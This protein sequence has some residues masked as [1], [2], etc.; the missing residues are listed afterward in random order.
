MD[1]GPEKHEETLSTVDKTSYQPAESERQVFLVEMAGNNVGQLQGLDRGTAIIGR[2]DDAD[3]QFMDAGIS[4]KHAEVSWNP[5]LKAY[6]LRDLHSR[7]GTMVN[8]TRITD[9]CELQ[10]GD[11]INLG[12]QT[13]LRVSY[14]DEVET[15][16]ASTMYRAVLRDALTGI[17][18]RRY[19]DERLESELSFATRH[20][21]SLVLLFLDIDHFK[22]INDNHEHRCGD[23]VLR[24]FAS[25]VGRLI[26]TEDIFAR[27]GGEEFAILCRDI[28]LW[29]GM[30]LA[31]RLR[32]A[33]ERHPFTFED[34]KLE[35]TVSVGVAALN[36]QTKT[37]EGLVTAA[38]K[39]LLR[40]K[41]LGRNKIISAEELG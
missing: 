21:T 37:P 19:L 14:S 30:I 29:Q 11:K 22:A 17:Y 33:V 5:A 24:Q 12:A 1:K 39:A 15:A 16:Y 3:I 9:A 27:Y 32:K 13:V 8:G 7:N 4:R 28:E 2:D 38:D 40:A 35:V 36:E 25:L 6:E 23:E 18:N 41:E 31:D 10:P 20:K 34:V 26:R